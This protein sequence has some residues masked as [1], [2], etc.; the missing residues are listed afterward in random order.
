M[1]MFIF[2]ADTDMPSEPR[3]F[4][5]SFS[6]TKAMKQNLSKF[7]PPNDINLGYK[8]IKPI[9]LP[10]YI[11]GLCPNTAKTDFPGILTFKHQSLQRNY[12][13]QCTSIGQPCSAC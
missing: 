11:Y 13:S 8:T 2:D 12:T 5:P 6:T 1:A 10:H 3:D 4:L 9:S 7:Q